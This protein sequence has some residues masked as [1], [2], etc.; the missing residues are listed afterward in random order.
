MEWLRQPG[1]WEK[2]RNW[3]ADTVV[4]AGD[5]ALTGWGLVEWKQHKLVPIQVSKTSDNS[6]KSI[7][8]YQGL[9]VKAERE[10]DT[11]GELAER[12]VFTNTGTTNL[13]FPLGSL[14]ITTPFFDQYP[15]SKVSLVSRCH[16]HLWMGGT[17]SWVNALRM[18]SDAPH[19]G[20]VVTQGGFDA[21]SQRGGVHD[22][23]GLFLLHPSAMTLKPGE[24]RTVAW[25]LFWHQ[26]WSDFFAKLNATPGFIRMMAKGYVVSS[27]HPLEVSVESAT[28]MDSPTLLANGTSVP[29]KIKDGKITDSIPTDKPGDLLVELESK[30]RKTWLRAFVIPPIDDLIEKRLKFIVRKQ[31]RNTKGDPLDGAYLAY[32][33]DI[34][35]QVY[36]AK[37]RDHNAGRERLAMGVLGALYLPLCKD[38]QFKAELTQSLVRYSDFINREM[39]DD[40]GIV[41]NDVGRRSNNRLYN[42]PWVAHF[43]LAMYRATG[44]AA[45]LDRFVQVMRSYYRQG[46]ERFYAIGIPI[47]DGLQALKEVGQIGRAHV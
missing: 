20:L 22:D 27:G 3:I 45:H 17:S 21:Y 5:S 28:S 44:D 46:G 18:G 37:W 32:D 38:P 4:N 23:R 15:N 1:H 35:E 16:T 34:E 9:T 39:E 14:S 24:S 10:I 33:N 26:G 25:K 2:G 43:H 40:Q 6:W 11:N 19:L 41:F 12:Y 47:T 7:Y 8:E 36:D 13:C 29:F 31:Q 42:Y 30:G